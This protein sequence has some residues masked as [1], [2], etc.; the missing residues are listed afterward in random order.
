MQPSIDLPAARRF[1]NELLKQTQGD[2]PASIQTISAHAS[3]STE[4][5]EMLA[6]ELALEVRDGTV[7]LSSEQRLDIA[8]SEARRGFLQDASRFLEWRDFERFA[9][10]CLEEMG[11]Q[12]S[13]DIRMTAEGRRW[14]I[15]VI[16]LKDSLLVCLDCKHWA[17]PLSP[18]RFKDPEAHQAAATR[19][20]ATKLARENSSV[21]TSLPVILT[22]YEPQQNISDKSVII[23][24]QKLPSMLRDLTPFDPGVPF[25]VVNPQTGENPISQ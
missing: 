15:D 13:R 24:V 2:K 4:L 22:L 7:K 9:E 6:S 16:G 17:P 10:R 18:S 5:S 11:F 21:I 12:S 23:E 20:Y 3:C 1:V 14:Q 25:I 8:M 19:L